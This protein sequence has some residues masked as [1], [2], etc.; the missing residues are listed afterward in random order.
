MFANKISALGGPIVAVCEMKIVPPLYWN[1]VHCAFAVL[2]V[3]D[4]WWVF[5]P[6]GVQFGPDWPLLSRFNDY[7]ARTRST[8]PS[9]QVYQGWRALGSNRTEER[10][11]RLDR[12]PF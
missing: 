7:V 3:G 12:S 10:R 6:T 8:I 4:G 9:R 1:Y 11:E 5:D 2:L